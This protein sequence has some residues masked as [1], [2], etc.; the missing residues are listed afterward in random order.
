MGP[1][2]SISCTCVPEPAVGR[3]A[4]PKPPYVGGS[5]W[6]QGLWEEGLGALVLARDPQGILLAF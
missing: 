3:G 1:R 5:T 6:E 2:K 4:T